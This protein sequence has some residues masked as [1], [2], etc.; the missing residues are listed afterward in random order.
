[1][2]SI[3]NSLCWYISAIGHNHYSVLNLV[4]FTKFIVWYKQHVIFIV[5]FNTILVIPSLYTFCQVLLY[6]NNKNPYTCRAL[7]AIV[8]L[9]QDIFHKKAPK[10]QTKEYKIIYTLLKNLILKL[11]KIRTYVI[12]QQERSPTVSQAAKATVKYTNEIPVKY[13]YIEIHIQICTRV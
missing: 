9:V 7:V 5:W 3:K 12:H 1:M 6:L 4:I 8:A 13:R 2:S 10:I 11:S